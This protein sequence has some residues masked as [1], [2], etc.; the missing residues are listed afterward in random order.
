MQKHSLSKQVD[1]EINLEYNEDEKFSRRR[2]NELSIIG[3]S[4]KYL[5]TLIRN[6]S[7]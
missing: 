5:I 4:Q 1:L 6:L 2:R 7:K 3:R